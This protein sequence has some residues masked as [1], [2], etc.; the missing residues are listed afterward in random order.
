MD[1]L[2]EY[3][4]NHEDIIKVLRDFSSS[5]NIK[6]CISSRPWNVFVDAFK[7]SEFVLKL[8]DMTKGDMRSYVD[9]ELTQDE[10]FRKIVDADK[11][12]HNLAPQ[13]TDRAHGV[14][15]WVYLVVRNLLRDIKGEEEYPFLQ[16]RLDSFPQELEQYFAKMLNNI[17]RIY[18]EETSEI[19]LLTIEA[20]KP[21][22][23]L[24]FKMLALIRDNAEYAL[25]SK[26]QPVHHAEAVELRSKWERLINSR[27]KD[28]LEITTRAD[29]PTFLRYRVDFLHR[30]VRDFLRD[31]YQKELRARADQRFDSIRT[32]CDIFLALV[33]SLPIADQFIARL[34][35]LFGLVDELLYYAREMQL[36]SGESNERLLNELDRVCAVHGQSCGSHWTNARDP[37]RTSKWLKEY[38]QCNFVALAIQSRLSAYVKAYLRSHPD[39]LENKRGRPLLDYALRP[40]RVMPESLQYQKQYAGSMIDIPTIRLLLSYGAD[41]NQRISIYE[42]QSVWGLFL[43]MCYAS[44]DRASPHV[45]ATIWEAFEILI[46]SGANI[47]VRITLPHKAKFHNVG[48][49]SRYKQDVLAEKE[50]RV[51]TIYDVVNTLFGEHQLPLLTSLIA[52]TSEQRSDLAAG[53]WWRW[54]GWR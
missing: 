2:D 37:S 44:A 27:C 35:Q 36:N 28:L 19:F 8:E 13:I 31:N 23:V 5:P 48:T 29:E 50:Q 32:L 40:V 7:H 16:R 41:P 51:L 14:W 3:E 1:G 47:N 52:E 34:D 54:L 22:P 6:L 20:V 21:L 25:E 42:N 49:T 10:H 53:T 38:G 18:L 30:T 11:R 26:I 45:K 39:A 15:L 17:D 12:C 33:K 24:A 9:K 4:G 46:H 43:G